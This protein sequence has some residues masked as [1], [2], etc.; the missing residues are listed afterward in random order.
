MRVGYFKKKKI[1]ILYTMDE[2][3]NSIDNVKQKLTDEEYKGLCD[4]MMELRKQHNKNE[5][6]YMASYV[7]VTTE[8]ESEH[9]VEMVYKLEVEDRVLKLKNDEYER[10]VAD[11]ARKGY[12]CFK[13]D[14]LIHDILQ[15][16]NEDTVV[17]MAPKYVA[18]ILIV[19]ITQ[20]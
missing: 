8:I 3:M 13:T 17:S 2:L 16:F 1:A 10:I 11:I 14:R 7:K 19:K 15:V 5:G 6:F 12:Y 9:A 18:E 20:A 4:Q